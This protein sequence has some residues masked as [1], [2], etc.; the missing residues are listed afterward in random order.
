MCRSGVPADTRSSKL[1]SY[2]LHGSMLQIRDVPRRI[3]SEESEAKGSDQPD[4]RGKE[5]TTTSAAGLAPEK[6]LMTG[7]QKYLKDET[8]GWHEMC[9]EAKDF[10]NP[11]GEYMKYLKE[12]GF[13]FTKRNEN[14]D[15]DYNA[16]FD[17]GDIQFP[18][19]TEYEQ[20][21]DNET[22][23]DKQWT[24]IQL[25]TADLKL[26][27]GDDFF[28]PAAIADGVDETFL[29]KLEME[30]CPMTTKIFNEFK[31]KLREEMN[32]S[33]RSASV[34]SL[35]HLSSAETEIESD[36]EP[37]P[38]VKI[39]QS[40]SKPQEKPVNETQ[41]RKSH[42]SNRNEKVAEVVDLIDSTTDDDDDGGDEDDCNEQDDSDDVDDDKNDGDDDDDDD[43][44]ED[45]SDDDEPEIVAGPSTSRRASGSGSNQTGKLSQ[46]VALSDNKLE[47]LIRKRAEL[48]D[49]AT[50]TYKYSQKQEDNRTKMKSRK[51]KADRQGIPQPGEPF[52]P[53]EDDMFT[54]L[55]AQVDDMIRKEKN[56]RKQKGTARRSLF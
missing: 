53:E 20:S 13:T 50:E 52:V 8:D 42:L 35:D 21:A 4:S 15:I 29:T 6:K 12:E 26:K 5:K 49:A 34:A 22:T 31:S 51:V 7:L 10:D 55:I 27:L 56:K 1:A 17:P 23:D 46:P 3:D 24:R 41:S 54:A 40:A 28:E 32:Y 45:D 39:H 16:V 44:E 48:M 47:E 33:S 38:V 43:D 18:D 37:E 36:A 11:S 9:Q 2:S 14:P 25:E 19:F 30:K